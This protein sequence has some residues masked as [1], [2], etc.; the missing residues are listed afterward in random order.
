MGAEYITLLLL[1]IVIILL[2]TEWVPLAVTGMMVPVVL[3]LTGVV[4]PKEAF[5]RLADP[6]VLLVTA[7]FVLGDAMFKVGIADKIGIKVAELNKK[8][9]RGDMSV[10]L[11]VM[12]IAALMST[13]LPNLGVAAALIPI[14][15]AVASFTGV[16]RSKLLMTLALASSLG[17]TITL[18][19]S[20]PNLMGR[21]ALEAAKV[22]TFGFFDFAYIGLPLAVL[23]I[24]F[25]VTLG[26]RYLPDRY[27][28]NKTD[29]LSLKQ[30]NKQENRL[31]Q[32]TTIILFAL[33]IIGII[34]EKQIGIPAF[35]TGVIG[36]VTIVLLKIMTEKQV[37]DSISWST[38]F[39]IVGML[40]LADAIVKS[41]A[42]KLIANG[43][44]SLFGNSPN[45]YI[46]IGG[47]FIIA[48]VLTQFMSNTAT[49]GMLSPIAISIASGISIDPR[50][51]V[52]AIC[53]AASCAFVTPIG[54]P[55]NTMVM[56]PGNLKFKDWVKVG[57][58]LILIAL[59]LTVVILP[60]VWPIN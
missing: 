31:K 40:S 55:A 46:L 24:L 18:I 8:F 50:P 5:L 32:L 25:I 42:S 3:T 13:V 14:V 27:V 37:Y 35:I 57:T 45:P 41:G 30:E 19:G 21:G 36:I 60:L 34:F 59:V 54:T 2:V 56:I 44:V 26:L 38:T 4:E 1:A 23:G 29:N 22:G 28:E 33:F 10:I 58:P 39:F 15:L 20:P 11:I 53:I 47:I 51:V 16:S 12:V 49:A 43:A 6:T 48:V 52:M 9:G 7:A 17:G